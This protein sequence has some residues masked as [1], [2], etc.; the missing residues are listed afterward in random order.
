MSIEDMG[1]CPNCKAAVFLEERGFE[2]V[3]GKRIECCKY[4]KDELLK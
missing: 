3:N 2:I 4:C 1:A